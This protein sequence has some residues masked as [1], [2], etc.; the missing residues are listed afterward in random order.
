MKQR[1]LREA[2]HSTPAPGEHEAGDRARAVLLRAYAQRPPTTPP[3]RAPWRPLVLA[4]CLLVAAAIVTPPAWP[5]RGTCLHTIRT[6][7]AVAPKPTVETTPTTRLPAPGRLL[8]AGNGQAW[9]L[10]A[11]GTRRRVAAAR[12]A[13][14]SP[15]GRFVLARGT[16]ELRALVPAGGTVRWAVRSADP[17][18]TARWSTGDGYRVAYVAAGALHVLNGDGTGRHTLPGRVAAVAPAWQPLR[19]GQPRRVAVALR[20][21]RIRVIDPDGNGRRGRTL[22]IRGR[23]GAV[24]R[25]L[26]W[27]GDGSRLLVLDEDA[28]RFYDA[29]GH[30]RGTAVLADGARARALAAASSGARVAL[31]ERDPGGLSAVRL[32]DGHAGTL[33]PRA[34]L[35]LSGRIGSLAFSPNG[36]WLAVT[37]PTSD[38]LLFAPVGHAG[39]PLAVGGL[40]SQFGGVRPE[41]RGWMP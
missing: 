6:T 30:L 33:A 17:I 14:W 2:L 12:D 23:P 37:W 20:S 34:V 16:G 25:Q 19:P 32:V 15:H 5:C 26:L 10:R 31:L 3:R 35:R 27:T 8:L 9:I 7:I 38:A 40:A 21:G 22:W 1:R 28:I 29:T 18:A 13:S 4:A 36:R 11:D 41:L 24:P 39:R